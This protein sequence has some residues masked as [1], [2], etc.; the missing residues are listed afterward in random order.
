MNEISHLNCRTPRFAWALPKQTWFMICGR[1]R[2]ALRHRQP[3]ETFSRLQAVWRSK[4]VHSNVREMLRASGWGGGGSKW[5]DNN[6]C[7]TELKANLFVCF[8]SWLPSSSIC[9][10]AENCWVTIWEHLQNTSKILLV[11]LPARPLENKSLGPV[12]NFGL[13]SQLVFNFPP[14]LN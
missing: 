8:L 14:L 3:E 12:L 5:Q 1:D 6:V 4:N 10:L 13:K 9:V 7:S 2:R 11:C